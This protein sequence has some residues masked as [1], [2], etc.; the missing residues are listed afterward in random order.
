[1]AI[2]YQE[3][4]ANQIGLRAQYINILHQEYS[5]LNGGNIPPLN[6]DAQITEAQI[7]RAKGMYENTLKSLEL[8]KSITADYLRNK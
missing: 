8:P 7:K 6:F 4:I 1:M 5:M 3:A 2:H